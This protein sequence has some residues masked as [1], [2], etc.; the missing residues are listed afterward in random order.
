MDNTFLM[1]LL[2][3]IAAL[4]PRSKIHAY[5][6]KGTGEFGAPGAHLPPL[7]RR[8]GGR[9]HRLRRRIPAG[10]KEELRRRTK[11]VK[12]L[13]RSRCP[14]S[15]VTPALADDRSLRLHQIVVGFDECQVPFEHAKHGAE[16]EAICTDLVK[17]GPAHGIV[18][19]FGTQRPDAKSLPIGISA[20]AIL[21]L[22]LKVT[23]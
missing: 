23:G 22:C 14:E 19:L 18:P 15:K 17:R 2:L 1:R 9:R 10:A 5:D 3:L 21:R 16:I 12:S 8:R 4:N 6:F 7:P 20:D 11:V 13:P